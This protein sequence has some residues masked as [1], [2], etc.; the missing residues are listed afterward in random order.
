MK[1][2]LLNSSELIMTRVEDYWSVWLT[3]SRLHTS[4]QIAQKLQISWDSVTYQN[5]ITGLLSRDISNNCIICLNLLLLYI[6]MVSAYEKSN[7]CKTG[8]LHVSRA[9]CF[10]CITVQCAL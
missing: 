1:S 2:S 3:K 9:K 5:N 7:Y 8:E 10:I 4:S 6:Y